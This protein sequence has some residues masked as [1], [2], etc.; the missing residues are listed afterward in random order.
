[1][2]AFGITPEDESAVGEEWEDI[3][4]S[5]DSEGGDDVEMHFTA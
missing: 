1:L 4:G 2:R 5:E 3:E